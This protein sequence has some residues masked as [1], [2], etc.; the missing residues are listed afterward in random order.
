MFTFGTKNNPNFLFD[1]LLTDTNSTNNVTL[2]TQLCRIFCLKRKQQ[3]YRH[4]TTSWNKIHSRKNHQ[5]SPEQILFKPFRMGK[6]LF[7]KRVAGGL[8]F[9]SCI[10][11]ALPKISNTNTF[12]ISWIGKSFFFPNTHFSASSKPKTSWIKLWEQN[13]GKLG[14]L[15][16]FFFF[17]IFF[18]VFFFQI[19]CKILSLR[20]KMDSNP[21]ICWVENQTRFI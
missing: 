1:H 7:L 2:C 8:E 18:E 13:L 21:Y 12:P 9:H 6:L 3:T 15:W 11:F 5:Q 4:I 16:T 17:Q 14:W 10:Q 20:V 19:S